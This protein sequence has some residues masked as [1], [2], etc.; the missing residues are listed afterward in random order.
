[1]FRSLKMLIWKIKALVKHAD[2]Y[3]EVI[4][5]SVQLRLLS[6]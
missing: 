1:M 5:K 4:V 3:L 6:I 2:F